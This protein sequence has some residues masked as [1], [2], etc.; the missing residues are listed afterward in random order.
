MIPLSSIDPNSKLW[1]YQAARNFNDEEVKQLTAH[2]IEFEKGWMSHNS[3]VTAA[4]E[5][6][7]NRFIVIAVDERNVPAGGCSIDTSMHFIK[8]MEQKFNVDLLNRNLIAYI[9][10]NDIQSCTMHEFEAKLADG[11]INENTLVFNNMVTTK[12]LF[13]SS[14]KVPVSKSWHKRFIPQ[15]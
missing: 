15:A 8:A 5:V 1:V 13:D 14:W 2:C 12:A 10:D 6:I 3:K 7:H 4:V 9:H 11:S